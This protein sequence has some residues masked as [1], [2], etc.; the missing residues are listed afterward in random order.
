MPTP[1]ELAAKIDAWADEGHELAEE[2]AAL[3]DTPA[4]VDP[5]PAPGPVAAAPAKPTGL[6]MTLDAK[7]LVLTWD[8]ATDVAEWDVLD[9]LSADQVKE[10][11]A[12]PRSTR[13]VWKQGKPPRRYAVRARNSAGESGLSDSID[14]PPAGET[15]APTPAPSTGTVRYP[16][17]VVG[18][19]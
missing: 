18:D 5:T 17:D 11:V 8:D 19:A 14:V 6:A 7:T 9:L 15:P 2:V 16:Y 12:A 3:D 1:D 4:P 13:S 10:T